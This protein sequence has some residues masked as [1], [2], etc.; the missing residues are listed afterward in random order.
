MPARYLDLHVTEMLPASCLNRGEHDL[1]KTFQ[2]G[3]TTRA[4]ITSQSF[5]RAI[6]TA[7]EEELNEYAVRT[8]RIPPRVIAALKRAGWPDDLADYAGSQIAQCSTPSGL[9]SDE[10]KSH[11]TQAL[12][13]TAEKALLDDLTDVCI[14]HRTALQEGL[15]ATRTPAPKGKKNEPARC[16]PAKELGAILARRTA[17]ITLFGRM[18]AGHDDSH[19]SGAVHMAWAFTTHTSDRQ[20]D[21]FTTKEDWDEPGDRGSA[22]LDTAFLTA[23]VFYRY[24]CVNLTELTANLDGDTDEALRLTG[25]FMDT[26]LL[27]H[28]GAK[29]TSTAP[30]TLPDTAAYVVRDRRPVSYA[31]AFDQPVRASHQGGYLASTR[32]ALSQQAA[33]T[34]RLIGARRRIGHGH[35]TAH[36]SPLDHLGPHHDGFEDLT[37]AALLA[38]AQPPARS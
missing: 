24:A 10:T 29:Q 2:L 18:L 27:T 12:I 25:L 11:R 20:P 8:R 1:P 28:P 16:L 6:R 13:Y 37:A 23:G 9:A 4:V 21:F 38:A 31:A 34:D 15:A 5:K 26:F 30:H 14:R 17:C 7:L 32:R 19:V 22:F 33:L 35:T 36:T 3:N